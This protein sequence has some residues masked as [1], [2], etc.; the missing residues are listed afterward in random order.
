VEVEEEMGYGLIKW[1]EG[2]G[3]V[4]S[5]SVGFARLKVFLDSSILNKCREKYIEIES[6]IEKK[7]GMFRCK[8]IK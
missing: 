1:R 4:S 5:D 6:R 2:G 8:R 3:S 7:D